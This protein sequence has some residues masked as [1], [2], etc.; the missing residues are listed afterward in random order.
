MVRAM[1]KDAVRKISGLG[2]NP[3]N[4][5]RPLGKMKIESTDIFGGRCMR[6]ND[7]TLYLVRR[8]EQN[9]G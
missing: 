2:R 6:G 9:C 7:D 8:V 3:I 4:V 1:K 5:F